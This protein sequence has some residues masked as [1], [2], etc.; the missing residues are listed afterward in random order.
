MCLSLLRIGN[1]GRLA[2]QLEL[3]AELTCIGL[4]VEQVDAGGLG[5]LGMDG[6][7]KDALIL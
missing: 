3:G 1:L 5:L 2:L 6:L 4:L 7:H